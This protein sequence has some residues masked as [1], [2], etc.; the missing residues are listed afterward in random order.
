MNRS[1]R[2]IRFGLLMI[3]GGAVVTVAIAEKIG[4]SG[5]VSTRSAAPVRF[6]LVGDKCIEG[7]VTTGTGWCCVIWRVVAPPVAALSQGMLNKDSH[8]FERRPLHPDYDPPESLP[9]WARLWQ[10]TD[11]PGMRSGGA[12]AWGQN[13]VEVGVG[14]P[15]PAMAIDRN[16]AGT[17]RFGGGAP[18]AKSSRA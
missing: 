14:W 4:V 16:I 17:D 6:V 1:R 12:I 8:V 11:W 18:L 7:S 13:A 9:G 3:L 10:P 2:A 15:L 5:T